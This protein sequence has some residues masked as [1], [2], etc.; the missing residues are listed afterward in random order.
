VLARRNSDAPTAPA[1]PIATGTAAAL[2]V[3][4]GI[5][6][7]C[8]SKT[9]PPTPAVAPPAKP[10]TPARAPPI[11]P[12]RVRERPSSRTPPTPSAVAPA[13]AAVVSGL[14]PSMHTYATPVQSPAS[15]STSAVTSNNPTVALEIFSRSTVP[16]QL[17]PSP[18]TITVPTCTLPPATCT[19]YERSRMRPCAV[20]AT[21]I[22][23]PLWSGTAVSGA[24]WPFVTLTP[25]IEAV[26]GPSTVAI[27]RVGRRASH[28]SANIAAKPNNATARLI[29]RLR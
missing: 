26:Q 21:G 28:A 20:P 6:Q 11:L 4:S 22:C 7:N 18:D 1:A 17:S 29:V 23:S 13:P 8:W 25:S 15:V 2:A 10:W 12:A 16:L 19:V 5:T 14:R 3:V 27:A 24:S 9:A